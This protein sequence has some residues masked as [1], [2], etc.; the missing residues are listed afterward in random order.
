MAGATKFLRLVEMGRK[1][2]WIGLGVIILAFLV[3][4]WIDGGRQEPR[5]IEQPVALSATG[6]EFTGAQENKE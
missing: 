1:K 2:I 5:M 3:V 6:G 4:A